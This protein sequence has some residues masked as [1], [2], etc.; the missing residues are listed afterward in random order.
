MAKRYRKARRY[1][2]RAYGAVKRRTAKMTIP[3]AVIG[4]IAGMPAMGDLIRS[5]QGGQ[6]QQIP[7]NFAK[8][9]GVEYNGAWSFKALQQNMTPLIAGIVA[10]KLAG[11]IGINAALARAKVPFLRV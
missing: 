3:I 8:M 2:R 10:H 9:V 6:Y 5:I 1:A 7:S 11:K 4:G